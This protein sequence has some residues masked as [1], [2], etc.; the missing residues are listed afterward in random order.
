MAEALRGRL[1][2][3]TYLVRLSCPC[4]H[5]FRCLRHI[6]C[7][8]ARDARWRC[9]ADRLQHTLVVML[10]HSTNDRQRAATAIP[11]C[12][13]RNR[14]H[15]NCVLLEHVAVSNCSS[16]PQAVGGSGE[17]VQGSKTVPH[18]AGYQQQALLAQRPRARCCDA[19]AYL[20]SWFLPG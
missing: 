2:I 8:E 16:D 7:G 11:Y 6:H 18:A 12:S 19:G 9:T 13:L 20:H 1:L 14:R 4:Q 3:V 10:T 15:K 5:T 17:L